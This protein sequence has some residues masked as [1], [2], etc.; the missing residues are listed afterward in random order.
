MTEEVEPENRTTTNDPELDA[1]DTEGDGQTHEQ[2]AGWEWWSRI[3]LG[4]TALMFVS[5]LLVLAKLGEPSVYVHAYAIPTLSFL[6]IPLIFFGLLRTLFRPPAIRKSRTIAF[7]ALL[8]TGLLGSKD[9]FAVPLS[10]E[11]WRSQSTYRVPFEEEAITVAGGD[12]IDRNPNAS[13][14]ATR[15]A[16]DF[17]FV[18]E[19][20][21]RAKLDGNENEDHYCWAKAVV[22]PVDGEVVEYASDIEDNRPGEVNYDSPMGNYV[23]IEVEPGEYVYLTN[24]RQN[25]VTARPGEA[26]LAGQKVGEC[27]NSGWSLS[28]HVH[29]RAQ[30]TRRLPSEGLP[31]RFD[32]A[33]VNGERVD[34]AMPRGATAEANDGDRVA[35]CP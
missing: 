9:M 18:G 13:H 33:I 14:A 35:P 29:L 1:H 23:V 20:G 26:V 15:W 25:T 2:E 16:Y 4:M 31:L 30:T 21:R 11:D 28:P 19:D 3:A 17:A 5:W 6:T 24:L 34:E 12:D 8:V 32:C 22:S 27:G 10:T 7:G